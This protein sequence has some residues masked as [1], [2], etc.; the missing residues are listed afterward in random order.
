[1]AKLVK[2]LEGGPLV[3]ANDTLNDALQDGTM[4]PPTA[5]S[6]ALSAPD[7]ARIVFHGDF[8]ISGGVITGGTATGFDLFLGSTK[9]MKATGAAVS[10][11]DL[12][13]AIADASSRSVSPRSTTT[14]TA[15][16]RSGDRTRRTSSKAG[17]AESS[18]AG[19]ATT[20]LL[21]FEG[22]TLAKGGDGDDVLVGNG[23][24]RLLGGEGED[25]FTAWGPDGG[26]FLK[27]GDF[28]KDF[29]VKDDVVALHPSFF[30]GP[31]E[32]HLAASYFNV[33]KAAETADHH[34]IY[35]KKTGIL[36]WDEDGLGG[37]A[38]VQ[39]ARLPDH[40]KLKADNI[41]LG[42]FV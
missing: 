27:G 42:D 7:G 38:Q 2:F 15:A 35:N 9:V 37:A 40:L 6:F 26:D 28:F 22:F 25:I 16:Q 41:F 5:T 39:V 24:S 33:G 18:S 8:T 20:T 36:Y 19:T 17:W 14:S 32:G 34:V 13:S 10:Y 21:T 23:E 31:P 29:T 12:A 3:S 4:E 11:A 1:M 30:E